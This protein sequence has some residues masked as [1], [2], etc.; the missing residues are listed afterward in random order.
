[1]AAPPFETLDLLGKSQCLRRGRTR[2]YLGDLGRASS[3]RDAEAGPVIPTAE[4]SGFIVFGVSDE[5]V[6]VQRNYVEQVPVTYP[7]L[8]LRGEVPNI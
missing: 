4:A 6:D 2:E 1:V 5:E 7:L 3:G 8:T